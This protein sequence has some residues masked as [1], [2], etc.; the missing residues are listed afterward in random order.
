M[1]RGLLTDITY[2]DASRNREHV[3]VK[4]D[5]YIMKSLVL[6]SGHADYI[7]VGLV[8]RFPFDLLNPLEL[9]LACASC[10]ALLISCTCDRDVNNYGALGFLYNIFES[11]PKNLIP[12]QSFA[13]YTGCNWQK[14]ATPQPNESQRPHAVSQRRLAIVTLLTPYGHAS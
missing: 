11:L 10:D 6:V 4:T 9:R 3:E 2:T 5:P 7:I 14:T 13:I 8:D 12:T 1:Q